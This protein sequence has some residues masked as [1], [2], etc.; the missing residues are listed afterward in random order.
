[1]G[2]ARQRVEWGIGNRTYLV[3]G[4][5]IF[6]LEAEAP[7]LY[8]VIFAFDHSFMGL[9]F[10][11]M[12]SHFRRRPPALCR[13]FVL[14]VA[15]LWM[16]RMPPGARYRALNF[17]AIQF[18]S[19]LAEE[20]LLTFEHDCQFQKYLRM[21]SLI[22][23]DSVMICQWAKLF[24]QLMRSRMTICSGV[25]NGSAALA[26]IRA[27]PASPRS[28]F[29]WRSSPKARRTRSAHERVPLKSRRER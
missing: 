17:F 20:R 24:T 2:T 29:V 26:T 12:A 7:Y 14:A 10:R 9:C 28:M 22:L 6:F 21:C 13:V 8:P 19:T 27:F 4:H 3:S 25:S 11:R 1:M 5:F 18:I 16:L 23:S 15:Q